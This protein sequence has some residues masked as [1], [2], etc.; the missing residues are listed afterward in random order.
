VH[1][2]RIVRFRADAAVDY[3]FDDLR[4]FEGPSLTHLRFRW[5]DGRRLDLTAEE[6]PVREIGEAV[7]ARAVPGMVERWNRQLAAGEILVFRP[8]HLVT[9]RFLVLAVLFLGLGGYFLYRLNLHGVQ[10]RYRRFVTPVL[11]IGAGLTSLVR[12]GQ[13]RGGMFISGE[14]VRRRSADPV[15]PWQGI[16]RLAVR[17]GEVSLEFLDGSKPITLSALSRNYPACF[18]LL[19]DHVPEAA[20]DP[21]PQ[22]SGGPQDPG[23]VDPSGSR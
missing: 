20:V 22:G 13:A 6:W 3:R 11:L 5:N 14:G 12:M 4:W 21:P 8:A 15:I 18:A 16:R 19:G 1:A 10:E 9:I 2:D 23:W 7:V 17:P